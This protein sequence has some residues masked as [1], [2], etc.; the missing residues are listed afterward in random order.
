MAKGPQLGPADIPRPGVRTAPGA[1]A[2]PA[3]VEDARGSALQGFSRDMG[4]VAGIGLELHEKRKR[5][6]DD[7]FAD[8]FHLEYGKRAAEIEAEALNSPE[9]G[10]PRFATILD[11]RLA[12]TEAE[13]IDQLVKS[14]KF[15]PSPEGIERAGSVSRDVRISSARR[16]TL[17]AHNQR[18]S[19]LLSS[20]EEN[21]QE[22]ARSAAG[23]GNLSGGLERANAV[24][25][26]V[27]G[28]LAPDKAK[29]FRDGVRAT[30]ITMVVEGHLA[31]GEYDQA[32]AIIDRET[33]FAGEG[34]GEVARTII[35][36]AKEEGVDPA[37]ALAIAQIES[38]LD[39]K[40][41]NQKSTA[42]GI[43]QFTAGTA[44]E[45]GL[46]ADAGTATVE[47]QA[48]GGMALISANAAS[49]RRALGSEPTPAE[50]Y[51]A[52]FLGSG[53]AIRVLRSDADT[54]LSEILTPQVIAANPHLKG[55]TAANVLA[56]AKRK[57]QQGMNAAGGALEGREI[58]SNAAGL[59]L[60]S[61]ITLSKR[62]ASAR[63]SQRAAYRTL[64][65]DDEASIRASGQPLDV[66]FEQVRAALDE[67]EIDTWREKRED[68]S[69]YYDAVSDMAEMPSDEIPGRVD[70]LEPRP[71]EVGF[72]RA[73]KLHDQVE[74][75]ANRIVKLRNDDP[76]LSVAEL[77]EVKQ[78]AEAF[79]QAKPAESWA[80]LMK[81]RLAAQSRIG[82]QEDLASVLTSDEAKRIAAPIRTASEDE[83]YSRF[84]QMVAGIEET[85][86]DYADEALRQ[87]V[88]EFVKSEDKAFY[89]SRIIR[90]IVDGQGVDQATVSALDEATETGAMED[91]ADTLSGQT[92]PIFQMLRGDPNF[93]AGQRIAIDE[94]MG[95]GR[96]LHP[97]PDMTALQFLREFP[98]SLPD[99]I[100]VYGEAQVP[101]EARNARR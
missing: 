53:D 28:F 45:F 68:A 29:A 54:K 60:D 18:V 3:F 43:F 24:A 63:G 59:P 70:V 19:L 48:R 66:D 10:D 26:S 44:R 101:A 56:W 67:D 5:A 35:D 36:V 89:A 40:A 93:Q 78:A 98:E 47:D 2:I 51:L 71:S 95:G 30:T 83:W 80:A 25:D 94:L 21:V 97:V 38:G 74:K 37:V 17:T 14:G 1:R 87:V 32:Q 64:M 88:R 11:E 69:A 85:F 22:I 72:A 82:I 73:E 57:M 23:S 86:G 31:R 77:A 100:A 42:S 9:A 52:H 33:G 50:V 96:T 6:E 65:N 79:D 8:T 76:A 20:A 16:A 55:M 99:F 15:S 61:A 27:S 34:A 91:A 84:D 75:E 41:D 4:V 92:D 90:Q 49:L 7:V 39:P 62:V 58:A 13:V 12:K 46:P 81:A